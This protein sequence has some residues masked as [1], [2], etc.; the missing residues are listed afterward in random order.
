MGRLLCV[1]VI[2]LLFIVGRQYTLAIGMLIYSF[3][4]VAGWVFSRFRAKPPQ[5]P[6]P[7]P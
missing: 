2:A 4:G 3:Y 7:L 1:L 6:T 5:T